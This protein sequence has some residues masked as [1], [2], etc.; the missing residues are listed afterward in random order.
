[1]TKQEI[2]KV[3]DV[4]SF[5]DYYLNVSYEF[6]F[7]EYKVEI[8][9]KLKDQEFSKT[10]YFT[11]YNVLEMCKESGVSEPFSEAAFWRELFFE[12]DR[13]LKLLAERRER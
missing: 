13:R 4:F 7:N 1:M 8:F 11:S 9:L 10:F 6:D 2:E 3:L 5:L 12:A